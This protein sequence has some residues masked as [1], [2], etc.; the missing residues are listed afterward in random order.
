MRSSFLLIFWG[1]LL[2]V[3]PFKLNGVDLL[4]DVIGYLL[5]FLGCRGLMSQAVGFTVAGPVAIVLMLL[6]LIAIVIPREMSSVFGT[7]V[8]VVNLVLVWYLI[9][10]IGEI[11]TRGGRQEIVESSRTRRAVY[12]VV[13]LIVALLPIVGGSF[14]I[15]VLIAWLV[16]VVLVLQLVYK[17]SKMQP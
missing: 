1:L 2:S 8:I 10:G 14:G 5:V 9:E 15:P 17:A 13:M 16:A 7:V 12:V 4:P 11:A 3:F 6:W